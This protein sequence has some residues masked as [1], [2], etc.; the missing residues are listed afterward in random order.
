MLPIYSY[1]WPVPLEHG[2]TTDGHTPK[3]ILCPHHLSIPPQLRVSLI[4]PSPLYTGM[5]PGTGL[6]KVTAALRLHERVTTSRNTPSFLIS[7]SYDLPSPS[8]AKLSFK[9]RW[10]VVD[11]LFMAEHF[12]VTCSLPSDRLW[13]CFSYAYCTRTSDKYRQQQLLMGTQVY[14]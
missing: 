13:V 8:S 3:K 10:Q 6:L 5:L 2:Q 4:I 12:I 14:A 7:G 11:V 9:E 1:M